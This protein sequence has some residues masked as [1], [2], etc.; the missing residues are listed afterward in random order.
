MGFAIAFAPCGACGTTFGF[1]PLK[2]PSCRPPSGG[3]ALPICLPCITAANPQRVA[4]G[5]EPIVPHPDAYEACD[6]SELGD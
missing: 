6:E 2:V 3:P 4:K 1:N 5:L